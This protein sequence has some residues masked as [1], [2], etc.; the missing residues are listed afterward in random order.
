MTFKSLHEWWK[1][2]SAHSDPVRWFLISS[3]S[4][5]SRTWWIDRGFDREIGRRLCKIGIRSWSIILGSVGMSAAFS[6]VLF[7]GCRRSS[8]SGELGMGVHLTV[9]VACD[10]KKCALSHFKVGQ[11]WITN[12]WVMWTNG[13]VMSRMAG[14]GRGGPSWKTGVITQLSGK[15]SVESWLFGLVGPTQFYASENVFNLAGN[16]RE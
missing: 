13:W 15:D 9:S 3:R 4:M 2:R 10:S 16:D 1:F 8:M 11:P 12:F 6:L 5:R 7:C 14:K